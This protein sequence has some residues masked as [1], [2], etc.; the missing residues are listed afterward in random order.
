MVFDDLFCKF[1]TLFKDWFSI[2]LNFTIITK[3]APFQ[4]K[5]FASAKSAYLTINYRTCKDKHDGHIL[6]QPA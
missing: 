3:N 2:S 5:S 4:T 1:F 6:E